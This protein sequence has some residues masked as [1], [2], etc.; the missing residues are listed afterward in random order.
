[1]DHPST[2]PGELSFPQ[3][4]ATPRFGAFEDYEHPT[5]RQ[6]QTP[7]RSK[8]AASRQTKHLLM[9]PGT[10]PR[11]RVL[12]PPATPVRGSGRQGKKHTATK[13]FAAPATRQD[14]IPAVYTTAVSD[15]KQKEMPSNGMWYVFRG[16]KVFRPFAADDDDRPTPTVLFPQATKSTTPDSEEDTDLE[17]D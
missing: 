3:T 2:P 1:M 9:T 12:F 6:M 7:V 14:S 17:W 16:K 11:R 4:P 15:K 5:K 10:T 8:T 13:L